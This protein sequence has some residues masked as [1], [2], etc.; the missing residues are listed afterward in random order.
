MLQVCLEDKP[1][2]AAL[3]YYWGPPCFDHRLLYNGKLI[4]ITSNLSSA[5]KRYRRDQHPSKQQPLWV[6]ALCINQRKKAELNAQLMLVHL[7][8]SG[9]AVVDIN[10]GHVVESWYSGSDL[11]H[12]LC[13][14][15]EREGDQ[16]QQQQQSR[17]TEQLHRIH[18]IPDLDHVAWKAYMY[19]FTSPWFVR[20]WTIQ[21]V[22]QATKARIRF[23]SFTFD[24]QYLY[25]SLVMAS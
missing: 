24:W 3:S 11:L 15:E 8:Y 6:D 25:D 18:S 19:R 22:V 7:I 4:S 2:Y 23:G 12:K 13:F 5:L 21:E 17:S 9:V 1:K 10:P 20:T 16:T 14:V